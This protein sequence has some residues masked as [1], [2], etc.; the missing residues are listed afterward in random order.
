M[1][2]KR[3]L[4]PLE[5]DII[6]EVNLEYTV[7]LEDWWFGT[8]SLIQPRDSSATTTATSSSKYAR[9]LQPPR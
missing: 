9:K 3:Q 8:R 1:R 7:E 6:K 5:E 4:T 2:F